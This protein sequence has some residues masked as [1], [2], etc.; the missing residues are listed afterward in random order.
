MDNKKKIVVLAGN[1][2]QFQHWIECNIIPVTCAEDL[3]HLRGL[4]D[5]EINEVYHEGTWH[6]WTNK[7]LNDEIGLLININGEKS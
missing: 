4:R 5:V 7:E 3:H 6:E 2:D 1:K